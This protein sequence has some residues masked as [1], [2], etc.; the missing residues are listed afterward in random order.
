MEQASGVGS[1][2]T[3]GPSLA[4][5]AHPHG[6]HGGSCTSPFVM[7]QESRFVLRRYRGGY[8]LTLGSLQ[9]APPRRIHREVDRPPSTPEAFRRIR[10]RPDDNLRR[11]ARSLG[12][13]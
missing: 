4:P 9:G 11:F 10:A 6:G 12:F 8:D 1:G 5:R 2:G 7:L 3:V 13:P